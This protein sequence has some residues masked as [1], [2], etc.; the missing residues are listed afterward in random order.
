MFRVPIQVLVYCY[1]KT[2][3]TIEY[4]LLKRV[5]NRGGFWQG[6]SGAPV[7]GES[8]EVAARRELKEETELDVISIHK[9]KYECSFPLEQKYKHLYAPG[10]QIIKEF[11]FITEIDPNSKPI[12]SEEHEQFIWCD[13][14]SGVGILKYQNNIEALQA[15]AKELYEL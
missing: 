8:L 1:R 5:E 13:L 10:V 4:L 9:I 3:K 6:I 11:V 12:L 7:E 14:K 2:G 15:C